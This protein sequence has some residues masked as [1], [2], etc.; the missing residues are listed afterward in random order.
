MKKII[1]ISIFLILNNCGYEAI[2]IKKDLNNISIREHILN[3]NESINRKIISLLNLKKVNKKDLFLYDLVLTSEKNRKVSSRDSLGNP[4]TYKITGSVN[5]KLKNLNTEVKP[6]KTKEF[7]K[8]TMYNNME[9]KFDFSRYEKEIESNLI[10]KISEEIMI[11]M[12][13]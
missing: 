4:S 11:F 5:F 3:G 13:S 9:N 7:T 1:F 2:Y 8:S 12:N 6:F 10:I